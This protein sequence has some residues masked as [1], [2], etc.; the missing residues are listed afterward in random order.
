MF[1]IGLVVD[2]ASQTGADAAAVRFWVDAD[3]S[4]GV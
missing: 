1:S 3:S 4:T 2:A